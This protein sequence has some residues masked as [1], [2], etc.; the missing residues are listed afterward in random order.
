[1]IGVNKLELC[2]AELMVALQEYLDKR[3]GEYAP[4]VDG[5][6]QD[7]AAGTFNIRLKAKETK[8]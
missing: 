6:A 7:K 1:M 2:E 3:M 8:E 4:K 5:V